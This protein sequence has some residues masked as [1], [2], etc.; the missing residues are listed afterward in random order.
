ML[1]QWNKALLATV[2]SEGSFT[3]RICKIPHLP[4]FPMLLN[5]LSSDTYLM[6][7]IKINDDSCDLLFD[8]LFIFLNPKHDS[9]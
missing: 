1:L 5:L 6:I 3:C 8:A 2:V 9:R 7:H 4:E